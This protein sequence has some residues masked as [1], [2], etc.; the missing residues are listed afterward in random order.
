MN[1]LD[2]GV[3]GNCKSIALI[4]RYGSIDWCCLPSFYSSSVF[5]KIL[6]S[7]NGGYFS[8]E[9]L[10]QYRIEQKYLE[11]TNVLVTCFSCGEHAFDL[12]D[13]MPRYKTEDGLYHCPPEI[14][15]YVRYISGKPRI[16]I[17]YQP[18]P[19]YAQY[20]TRFEI[21][22]EF[23][24]HLTV[25]GPYESVYLY[26]DL[27]FEK[28]VEA[29]PVVLER[30][31]FF[32]VSY[33]QALFGPD[34]DW[35]KLEFERTKVYW[36]SWAT[37][38]KTQSQYQ[39]EIIRSSLVLKLLAYQKTGAILA[40]ATTS[41]PETIGDVRNWD[42]RFCWIRDASMTITTLARLGH[43]NV[44]K[45]FLQF[46]LDIVPYKDEEIQIL[47]PINHRG[48]VAER[49]LPWLEGY[50]KS[51]PVRIGN[52][53]V[54]QKQND[55][56]GV[57]LDAIYNSLMIFH[58]SMNGKE[59]I[60]TV[61]RTL[62]R[63]V[64]NNWKKLDSSIWEFRTEEKHFTFS[65]ILCW[66]AMDRAAR[67][68]HFFGKRNDA[69]YF[70][71]NRDEIKADILAKGCDPLD[72]TLTQFYGGTSM[73]AANLLAEQYGF[74]SYKDPIYINT[75]LKTLKELSRDGL[76]YRYK[77]SDDFGVPK[78][79][80]IV[81]T[82]WMIKSL[83]L[84]GRRKQAVEMFESVLKHSNHLGLFSE[85]M[86]FTSK[87]LLGNFPQGYSHIALIDTAL[88]I[89]NSPEWIRQTEHFSP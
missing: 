1:N 9:P 16:R 12:I 72:G 46:I 41:I 60:W 76:M 15:R 2:Y 58:S 68:A 82:F 50:E 38:T 17:H 47:Y 56:Y 87:R 34:I 78:S 18:R 44:A 55:I 77:S 81:C 84:I 33:N 85:D 26:T 48:H 11:K 22:D 24:K 83:Y 45:R 28:V 8:I 52:A 67:I 14:I 57:L 59:D 25:K 71:K 39:R 88:T 31:C 49:E 23:I 66:V 62:A 54:N 79:S 70:V 73:D 75:V 53:A 42:Y 30:D 64:L 61:V 3:I 40:A 74:L 5:A 86:D 80:F 51:K 4:D 63:H 27:P 20:P 19:A 43:F 37:K 10:G 89:S 32:L 35:I 36:M 65:K 13:F 69:D 7:C 6:D 29:E 21:T